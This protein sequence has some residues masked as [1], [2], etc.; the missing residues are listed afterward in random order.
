MSDELPAPDDLPDST[1]RLR[2]ILETAVEAIITIDE[3]GRIESANPATERL[4][5]L[6]AAELVGA[7]NMLVDITER[8][9]SEEALRKSERELARALEFHQAVM[10]NMG[11][12]LYAVD[13]Q[14]LVTYMNPAAER[15]FGWSTGE[16]LGRKMHDATHYKHP[17]GSPFPIEECAVMRVLENGAAL[18]GS[19]DVFIRKDGSFFPVV[20]SISPLRAE[21]AITGLVVVFRDVTAEKQAQAAL[22]ENRA[23]LEGVV[24]SAMDAI[25]TMDAEQQV[26]LFNAAAEKMFGCPAAQALGS[27][28]DRFIPARLLPAQARRVQDG[29]GN[30]SAS[31]A[32]MGALGALSAWRVDG[33]E[34]PIEASVSQVEV[35]GRKF[36]TV[37][38]RDV[39]ERAHAEA[40]AALRARQQAAVADLNQHALEGRDLVRLTND[41]VTLIA[42]VLGVELAKMLELTPT[43]DEL[44]LRAGVG[45]REG[46]VGTRKE[47]VGRE[48][49]AGYALLSGA[50]VVTEEQA[51]ETRFRAA[52]L[53]A[54]HGAV[55]GMS[56]I[57]RGKIKPYGVLG[58]HTA[59]HRRFSGD[60]V[61]F[62]QS[63]A[64]VLAA[65]IER[66]ELEEELLA[67]A[68][69]EQRRIGQDLHDGLCQHL[70]GVEFR[71]EALARDLA[72]HPA[73]REEAEKI[74]A[75]IR[76]G[77]RQARMLARGLAPVEMEKNGLMSAL[78][79]L[80]ASSAH[81]YRIE[82]RFEC[83]HPVL[84]TDGAAA[85]HLYRIAQEAISNAVRHARAKT[86]SLTLRPEG[87]EAVLTISN[88]GAPLPVEPQRGGGM[89]LRIM[90]YRAELI[91]AALRLGSSAEGKTALS[92]TFKP[93]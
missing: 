50:P 77:T 51:R 46:C 42:Q 87:D 26:V 76:E 29:G 45:W 43:G 14:G 55:S 66:R 28:I 18:R 34:F 64:D 61:H 38:L 44:I 53:L 81:L 62:L 27:R 84:V 33:R 92:C 2:A 49:Q 54:E 39:T 1:E 12:G 83:E 15:L 72:D 36:L 68:G 78:T 25:I 63:I 16:L 56:V 5:G 71:T 86:I 48:S 6:R 91:G 69:R 90:R 88:D 47:S 3:R 7:V 73:G 10:A 70:A 4:F 57:I 30:G 40:A 67:I 22:E 19:E 32:M 75:L 37:I 60:D 65:A 80:A 79:E 93:H 85:T 17:G 59:S 31:H 21:D 9:R 89:G 52:D 11:E 35:R 13:A 74:G 23:R 8:K 20:Y 58:A 24:G 41:A 82:C